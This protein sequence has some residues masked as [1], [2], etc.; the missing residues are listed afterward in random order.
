MNRSN[1][2]SLPALLLLVLLPLLL[3]CGGSE[4][5]DLVQAAQVI[6]YML[7]PNV[8]AN[9]AFTVAFPDPSPS[10]F[11]SYVF[12]EMGRTEWEIDTPRTA[13]DMEQYENLATPLPPPGVAFVARRVD[14]ER[15]R[16]LVVSFD[17]DHGLVVVEGFEDPARS[18]VLRRQ[19]VLPDV[20]PAP[21]VRAIY[22]ASQ[23][24][25]MSCQAF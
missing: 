7:R 8:L 18:P 13:E 3:V 22:Q 12:S 17:D 16:Q 20:S 14:P 11:V 5:A 21:G 4:P 10:Q 15:G 2:R 19:W 23:Q 9:S 1:R 6:E 25:G 24:A